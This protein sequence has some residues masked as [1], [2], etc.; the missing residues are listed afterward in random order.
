MPSENKTLNYGLNQWQG[1]EYPKR[2]DFVND[3]LII[4]TEIKKAI[5]K[6]EQAFQSAS[7]GKQKIATAIT[8][9]GVPTGSSDTF[10]KMADNIDNIITD[11]SIGTTDAVAADILA[12]KKVVSQGKLLIGAMPNRGAAVLTP[13][14]S[15]VAIQNGYHNGSGHVQ[16]DADFVESNI[17]HNVNLWGKTGSFTGDANAIASQ[18]LAG[19]I[20]YV[21]GLKVVGTMPNRGAINH[22]LPVNGS[23]TISEGYHNG[24]GKVTQNIPT[25]AAATITPGTTNQTIAANQY[26]SGAQTILGSANLAAGNI[27][28]GVNIFGKIGNLKEAPSVITNSTFATENI[29][30]QLDELYHTQTSNA[31]FLEIT[32]NK[33]YPNRFDVSSNIP[34]YVGKNKEIIQQG[35]S[36]KFNSRLYDS[37]LIR[38]LNL[39]RGTLT[40]SNTAYSGDTGITKVGEVVK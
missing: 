33:D 19:S 29:E 8:G 6:A 14:T 23:F 5:S 1:N 26:L 24:S 13:G 36:F 7:D 31:I 9:K 38:I 28:E 34:F 25:K 39:G 40:F 18:I 27:K 17:K 16:G 15:N 3:N 11:P 12:P 30:W 37:D 22:S 2:Q 21:Q 32:G 10:Q 20:A 4:D 35:T